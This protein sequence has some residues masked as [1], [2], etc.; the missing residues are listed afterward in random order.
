MIIDFI[1]SQERAGRS[2]ES[3]CRV[4]R[5]LDCQV[6]ARTYRAA[7]TGYA[8]LSAGLLAMAYLMNAIHSFAYRWDEPSM[9]W[10]L[11]PEGLYGRRKMTVLLEREGK[12][13]DPHGVV[14]DASYGRVHH[15]MHLLRHNGIRRARRRRQRTTIGDGVRAGDL[16][17]R[18][19][20]APEPNIK[21]V[22]D[23]TYVHTHDG[24]VY[25]AF[26]IDCFSHRIISW[27]A[28][29]S[30]AVDLVV[31]AVTMATAA[32]AREGHPVQR[33]RLI[34]HSDAG[35]QYT[36]IRLTEHLLTVGINASIGTVGDAYDTP[37]PRRT[38]ACTRANA[39][40][41]TSSTTG[42]GTAWPMSKPPPRHGSPGTVPC[43]ACGRFSAVGKLGVVGSARLR[44]TSRGRFQD[45][46]SC[47]RIVLN[48]VRYSWL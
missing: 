21:W 37:S 43:Q 28:S 5:E 6:A 45:S 26:V 47:G 14:Q 25:V 17:G 32:R 44:C 4:L 7:K 11:R 22:T 8:A 16:L 29:T 41:P 42:P 24:W 36:S 10:R 15:A 23:F 39:S 3:A 9:S 33:G 30:K 48:S 40:R 35:S 2:V 18:D 1:R 12:P 38:W 19:F 31:N 27:S 13:V 20:T 34:H 46:A